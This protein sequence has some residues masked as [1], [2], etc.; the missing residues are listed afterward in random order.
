M[1]ELAEPSEGLRILHLLLYELRHHVPGVD[2]DGADGHD[3]LSVALGEFAQ[4]EPDE[5]VQLRDLGVGVGGGAAVLR[6]C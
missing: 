6:L 2:V 5:G 4:Q 3:A 1:S